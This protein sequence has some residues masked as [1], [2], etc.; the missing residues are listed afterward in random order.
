MATLA[1]EEFTESEFALIEH[2]HLT[3]REFDELQ[4]TVRMWYG[5]NINDS[6]SKRHAGRPN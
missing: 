3:N 1:I 6:K 2:D 4:Q 5:R